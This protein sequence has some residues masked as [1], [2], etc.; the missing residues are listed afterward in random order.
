MY[1]YIRYR[2]EIALRLGRHAM[3]LGGSASSAPS[4][5]DKWH[6]AWTAM[7]RYIR[8][9]WEIALRL[10]RHAMTLGGSASSA[11]SVRDK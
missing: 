1:R 9:R 4:V 10:G 7:Y 2:W 3:T 6:L 8:Y 5:R 11:P